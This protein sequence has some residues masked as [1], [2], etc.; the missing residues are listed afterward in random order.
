ME[1][2]IALSNVSSS[3]VNYG[4]NRLSLFFLYT[5]SGNQVTAILFEYNSI[6]WSKG[7]QKWVIFFFFLSLRQTGPMS[8]LFL[9]AETGPMSFVKPGP[10]FTFSYY[11]ANWIAVYYFLNFVPTGPMPSFI[12]HLQ[13]GPIFI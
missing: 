12:L 2:T 8:T 13:T 10:I 1:F 5:T 4:N 3:S 9:L 6:E 7:H 11:R